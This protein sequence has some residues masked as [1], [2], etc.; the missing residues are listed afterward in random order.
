MAI[1]GGKVPEP[2][3]NTDA[4]RRV[5][6]KFRPETKIPNRPN[7]VEHLEGDVLDRWKQLETTTPG[8]TLE[9]YFSTL[10]QAARK[11]ILD[12]VGRNYASA[13]LL[14]S[15]PGRRRVGATRRERQR[16]CPHAKSDR[17]SQSL[18]S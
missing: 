4:P 17:P 8:I 11:I 6:V 13:L 1:I 15:E 12:R 14:S 3:P 10:E 16:D 7:P 18:V 2:R 5:V 9:P